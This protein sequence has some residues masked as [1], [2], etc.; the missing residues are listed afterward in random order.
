MVLANIRIVT[1]LYAAVAAV[2]PTTAAL[3]P[4]SRSSGLPAFGY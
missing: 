2:H 3:S 4:P 1:L